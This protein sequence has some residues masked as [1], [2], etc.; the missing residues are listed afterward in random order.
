MS[1]ELIADALRA[2]GGQVAWRG[3]RASLTA[4]LASAVRP[5]DVVFTVGAGDVTKSGPE[6]LSR[7]A[8]GA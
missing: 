1:A 7:L 5:G 3:D 6:L 4:A 8:G 2:A